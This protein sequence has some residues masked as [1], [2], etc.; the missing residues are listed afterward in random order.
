MKVE[1]NLSTEQLKD[2]DDNV[3]NLLNNLTDEQKIEIIKNY[4]NFQ[5]DKL[6]YTHK[7]NFWGDKKEISEFGRK[8][9]TGLQDQITN[10]VSEEIMNDENLKSFI[11]ETIDNVKKDL[12]NIIETSISKYIVDNLFNSYH[13]I[14]EAIRYEISKNRIR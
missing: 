13:D 11:N 2:L 6:S 8:L 9:I 4:I 5:F 3:T 12:P 10:S 7:D 1:L 14:Q